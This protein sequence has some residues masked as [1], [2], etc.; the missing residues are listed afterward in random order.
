M[1]RLWIMRVGRSFNSIM[2]TVSLLNGKIMKLNLKLLQPCISQ[3][4][5]I[6]TSSSSIAKPLG[7]YVLE[8]YPALPAYAAYPPSPSSSSEYTILIVGNK[9]NNPNYWYFHSLYVD[10]H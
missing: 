9:Y 3:N 4:K 8:H 1:D 5:I 2:S 6:L 10:R 7:D